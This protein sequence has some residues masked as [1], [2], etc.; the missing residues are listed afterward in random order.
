MLGDA[1]PCAACRASPQFIMLRSASAAFRVADHFATPAGA[2]RTGEVVRRTVLT[3]LLGLGVL[4]PLL[5]AAQQRDVVYGQASGTPLL[6]DI[7]IPD[8][9]GP[10][11][12][13]ILVHGG[14]WSGGDKAGSDQPGN[15]ADITPWFAM[16]ADASFVSVSINY[17]LAPAHRWPACFEDVQTAI[18]WV[19]AHAAD[20]HGDPTRIALVGHS[21]G[22]HLVCL[23]A[24]LAG[25][26]T[27]VQAVVG[28]AAVTD[29]VADT[30]RRGGL[31]PSLQHL[32][33][34]PHAATPESLAV[35]RDLSPLDHVHRGL[36]PFLLLHGDADQT[37]PHAMS[38]A[39]QHRLQADGN[40]CDLLTIPG[41]PH[42]LLTWARLA[43]DYGRQTTLWLRDV[44]AGP[45]ANHSG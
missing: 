2:C 41:A 30:Q 26:D 43:P 42:G 33:G 28:F 19:K 34:L 8:G 14:G 23:A 16:F 13:A 40:R 20:Y 39:F 4:S 17:R 38:V 22:G 7:R 29:L 3:F 24:T 18:R 44:F 36:P 10:F 37:V 25:P 35:L 31:S 32:L 15:G 1:A 21:A 11:P 27:R 45:L 5:R 12:V 6:C 9:P